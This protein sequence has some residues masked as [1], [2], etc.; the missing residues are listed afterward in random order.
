LVNLL[1]TKKKANFLSNKISPCLD[2]GHCERAKEFSK[3]SKKIITH[4]IIK[5]SPIS[6]AK[7]RSASNI[8]WLFA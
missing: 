1:L 2:Q 8:I 4:Q 6:F 5:L 7:T 3:V